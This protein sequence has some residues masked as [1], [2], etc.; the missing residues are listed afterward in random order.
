MGL[1]TTWIDVEGNDTMSS[2]QDIHAFEKN[3]TITERQHRAF[4]ILIQ[5]SAFGLML[6][7][8]GRAVWDHGII[9]SIALALRNFGVAIWAVLQD[10]AAFWSDFLPFVIRL[11]G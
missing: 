4:W 1:R 10:S 11:G 6:G 8:M 9:N 3:P 2:Y 5:G 7:I